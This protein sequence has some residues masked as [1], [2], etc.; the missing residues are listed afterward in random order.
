[1]KKVSFCFL[2][3]IT[4][5]L[6]S[7]LT[8]QATHFKTQLIKNILT[9]GQ[10]LRIELQGL[11]PRKELIVTFT[12]TDTSGNVL[13]KTQEI[14]YNTTQENL[15]KIFYTNSATPIGQYIINVE[16][17][18]EVQQTAFEITPTTLE[19]TND[20]AVTEPNNTPIGITLLLSGVLI[21]IALFAKAIKRQI[22]HRQ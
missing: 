2:Y 11:G 1:M 8:G 16:T 18:T 6:L 22:I 9:A 20:R 17:D 12:I 4:A 19:S 14:F 7:P 15:A 13:S 3:L 21:T 5:S 10:P